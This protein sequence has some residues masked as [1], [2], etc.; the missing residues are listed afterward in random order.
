MRKTPGCYR[1]TLACYP[2]YTAGSESAVRAAGPSA[3]GWDRQPFVVPT[4]WTSAGV[5]LLL[6]GRLVRE[7]GASLAP[8]SR[9]PIEGALY[10]M[11]SD[12]NA[13]MPTYLSP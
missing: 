9:R 11:T 7:D 8:G 1:A 3:R 2:F 6:R 5:F 4:G 13:R 10:D 12:G